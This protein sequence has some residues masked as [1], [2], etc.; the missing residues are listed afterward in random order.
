MKRFQE[1]ISLLYPAIDALKPNADKICGDTENINSWKPI[2]SERRRA[3]RRRFRI[4]KRHWIPSLF[5]RRKRSVVISLVSMYTANIQTKHGSTESPFFCLARFGTYRDYIWAEWYSL[6]ESA[7]TAYGGSISLARRKRHAFIPYCRGCGPAR[8]ETECREGQPEDVWGRLG[9]SEGTDYGDYPHS[10]VRLRALIADQEYCCRRWRLLRQE[11]IIGTWR[12]SGKKRRSKVVTRLARKRFCRTDNWALVV[13]GIQVC[14]DMIDKVLC[15]LTSVHGIQTVLPAVFQNWGAFDETRIKG[16]NV[17]TYADN[18][19][20][21]CITYVEM[22][23]SFSAGRD[24][25]LRVRA[26]ASV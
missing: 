21:D 26:R 19:G 22:R 6:R 15:W 16:K 23:Q 7:G 18:Y 9:F 11:C 10:W 25:I 14:T 17:Q 5:Y 13:M 3:W 12:R 1:M 8:V 24:E 4:Y 20:Q 2:C